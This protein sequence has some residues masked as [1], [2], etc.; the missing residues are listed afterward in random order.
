MTVDTRNDGQLVVECSH[1]KCDERRD[2]TPTVEAEMDTPTRMDWELL[3]TIDT[4]GTVRIHEAYCPMHRMESALKEV[5]TATEELTKS[6]KR[7]S[8]V[9]TAVS[10]IDIDI[11]DD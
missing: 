8:N 10:E 9:T 5:I 7:V 6:T 3:S 2:F 1:S 4:D 11:D